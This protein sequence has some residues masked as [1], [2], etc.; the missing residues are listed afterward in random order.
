MSSPRL[1][2]K[3]AVPE[4]PRFYSVAQVARML[5]MSQMTVY[6]AIADGQFPAVRIRGRLIVPAKAIDDMSEVATSEQTVVDAA[7][8]VTEGVG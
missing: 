5:G 6:R 2:R 3:P 1:I 4:P 7:N 8:W